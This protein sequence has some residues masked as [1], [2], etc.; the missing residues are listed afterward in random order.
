MEENRSMV[1]LT[2]AIVMITSF[3]TP[4][5]G[6]AI[7]LG[8]PQMALEF[9]VGQSLLNWVVTS[10]LLASAAFLLPFGRLADIVGRKKVFTVGMFLFALTALGSGFAWSFS[11]FIIFRVLQGIASAMIFGTSMAIL[12]SVVPPKE[13][14][15]AMGLSAAS[16]YIGLSLGPV[17]GG[18]I[19][20]TIGWRGIFYFNFA[21]A[22]VVLCLTL[23]KL[24]GEWLGAVD[25]FDKWG[26]ILWIL[27][28]L[29]FLYGL[30]DITAGFQYMITFIL[31]LTLLIAFVVYE[32]KISNPLL[33]IRMFMNN[34][35]F[36][37]SNLAALINYSATFALTFLMS[38]YLQNVQNIET[39][40]SGLILL[41]QP[42]L[43][44]ALS[45][46]AGRLSDRINSQILASVGM[47]ITT[48]GLF[49]FIFLD[50]KTSILLVIINL[51]FIGL[52]FAFFS[53]PNSN[54]VM[55]SVDRTLYGVASSTLGTMRLLG[56]T[57]SM[58]IV[59][60]ITSLSM[61][62][63]TLDS[64]DYVTSFL[65]SS[66]ASFTV[67][68]VLCCIGIFASLAR[69]SAPQ[70]MRNNSD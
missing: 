47:A 19:C 59:A 22:L 52:G 35:A 61:K 1:K 60:L 2:M 38:L 20:S 27:G 64:P 37:F 29:L 41:S 14:G 3:I 18:V 5:M 67:F 25:K 30:T 8:I 32:T 28:I 21:L 10:Y 26:G 49:F 11:M 51:A 58:T 9:G 69:G 40:Q 39:S 57:L 17:L 12:T 6:N 24:S 50:E 54:A 43:M 4:F 65:Q 66:R 62:N 23:A 56:Q 16:T 7:N 15:K 42:I 48:L 46:L 44:A 68:S 13:R 33:P 53:S 70:T 36:T 45:P 55:S 31:G 63:L 34:R